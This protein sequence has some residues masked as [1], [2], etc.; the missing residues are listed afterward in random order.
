MSFHYKSMERYISTG[1]F[2][3]STNHVIFIQHL[4]FIRTL[5][6]PLKR[7]P[8]NQRASIQNEPSKGFFTKTSPILML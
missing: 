1:K 6:L 3:A 7:N 8:S 5:G 2:T 4:D